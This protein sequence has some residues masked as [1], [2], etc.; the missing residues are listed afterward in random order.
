MATFVRLLFS[1]SGASTQT[2]WAEMAGVHQTQVNRYLSAR[3]V[4]DGS[5][6]LRLLRTLKPECLGALAPGVSEADGKSRGR[7]GALEDTVAELLEWQTDTISILDEQGTR[8]ERLEN[9][10]APGQEKAGDGP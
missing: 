2:E 6:V 8:L 7:L 5:N 4:P 10:P 3:D 9:A 1:L